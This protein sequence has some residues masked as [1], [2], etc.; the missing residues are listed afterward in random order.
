[1]KFLTW[2]W[3]CSASL[4][5]TS[6]AWSIPFTSK[7]SLRL[8]T[9]LRSLDATFVYRSFRSTTRFLGK[10]TFRRCFSR[11]SSSDRSKT[12]SSAFRSTWRC[13]LTTTS[14][15]WTASV[16]YGQT[17]LPPSWSRYAYKGSSLNAD[18]KCRQQ[19]KSLKY[20]TMYNLW[21]TSARHSSTTT[22]LIS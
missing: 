22:T 21:P 5:Q 4:T 8:Q 10:L 17:N 12:R 19:W 9:R 20:S 15:M 14:R 2:G 3:P 7:A 1:M 16:R 6:L 18:A 11:S 13:C